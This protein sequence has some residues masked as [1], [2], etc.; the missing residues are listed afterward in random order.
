MNLIYYRP[1]NHRWFWAQAR[2]P[3]LNEA[4]PVFQTESVWTAPEL[5]RV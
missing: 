4:S 2:M 1:V 3:P 5:S